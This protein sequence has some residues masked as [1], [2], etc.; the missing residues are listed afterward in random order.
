[1]MQQTSPTA[2]PPQPTTRGAYHP[3]ASTAL[4]D[5]P[6]PTSS[7]TMWLPPY[8]P[9]PSSAPCH[10]PRPFKTASHHV[11]FP[12]FSLRPPPL[13]L[14]PLPLDHDRFQSTA[15]AARIHAIVTTVPTSSV[16]AASKASLFGGAHLPHGLSLL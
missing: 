5:P 16:S 2:P 15:R 6:P 12:S 13:V 8:R 14:F 10:R 11:P 4:P 7:S 3:T 9:P 1:M